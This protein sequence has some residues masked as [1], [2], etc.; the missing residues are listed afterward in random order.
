MA[1]FKET[2]KCWTGPVF[3]RAE[4]SHVAGFSSSPSGRSGPRH[5]KGPLNRARLR[6]YTVC[7]VA[8][9]NA[10]QA[11]V[12]LSGYS[13]CCG[14]GWV[15]SKHRQGLDWLWDAWLSSHTWERA[16]VCWSSL[17][18]WVGGQ[19][20]RGYVG[21]ETVG[22]NV[23]LIS[24]SLLFSFDPNELLRS[25]EQPQRSAQG[26]APVVRTLPWQE[27]SYNKHDEKGF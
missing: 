10:G 1:P 6:T 20:C 27:Y 4:R 18:G 11:I 25:S 12:W 22:S 8:D 14:G 7:S 13:E 2:L 21:S 23:H 15:E 3:N 9:R 26:P 19:S 16:S 17:W 24:Y 5:I